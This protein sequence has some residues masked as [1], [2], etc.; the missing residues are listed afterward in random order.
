M[1]PHK[2]PVRER[3]D[4]AG[5]KDLVAFV[6]AR[7][8]EL[9]DPA[10]AGPMAAYMRTSQPF[11]GVQRP[12]L[13]TVAREVLGRFPCASRTTYERNTLAL[14]RL[15]HREEQYLA[16]RWARQTK[17]IGSESLPMYERLIRDGAWWDFVD[18][19]ASH[20]IGGALNKARTQE[21]EPVLDR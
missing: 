21:I 5:T 11:H 16:I 1:T 19:I 9:A 17:W 18:E 12:G 14:W 2:K 8:R 4:T 6:T 13:D 20:L 15:P 7:L 3:S 10:K